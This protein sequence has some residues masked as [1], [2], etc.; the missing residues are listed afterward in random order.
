[1]GKEESFGSAFSAG[2][3]AR[4][5]SPL[6]KQRTEVSFLEE[7]RVPLLPETRRRLILA[8]TIT[9][10]LNWMLRGTKNGIAPTGRRY[11]QWKKSVWSGKRLMAVMLLVVNTAEDRNS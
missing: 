6:T 7:D 2:P 11:P 1:M 10:W 8:Y 4:S 5:F 3:K 9:G